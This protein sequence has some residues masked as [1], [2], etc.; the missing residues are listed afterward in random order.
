M[1]G[2]PA[3]GSRLVAATRLYRLPSSGER[4]TAAGIFLGSIASTLGCLVLILWIGT[5]WAAWKL[6]YQPA[7]GMPLYAPGPDERRWLLAAVGVAAALGVAALLDARSRRWS[8]ALFAAALAAGACWWGPVY[9]PWDFFLWE[10]RYGSVPEAEAI[11]RTGHWL[12]GAP[13]HFV[14]L[15]GVALA[16]RRAR[17][18]GGRT[19]SHGSA[20]WA[21]QKD[22]ARTGL[23]DA[24]GVYVGGW[25][26]LG[27]MVPLRHDGPQH[28]LGFAPARSGKGVGWVIPTL[29]A[30]PDSVVVN[31]IKGENW[32][33]TAGWRQRGLGSLCLK[34]DPTCDDGSA[35][36]YNPLLEVRKGPKE[37]RD[38]QNIADI[39]VDPDG[40]GS[41]D[42]WDLTAQE[43]LAGTI[44]HVLYAGRDKSLRGC[45][46]LLTN[47]HR[48][49]E[50]VLQEMID[51]QHDPVG[52]RNWCDA[53]TGKPTTTHPAVAR[54]ARSL[55]NKSEN[56]R[57]SVLSSATKFLSL[58]HDDVVATN[59]AACD[60]SIADLM[61]HDR[62]VSLYLT[63]PPSDLSRV[64]PLL[65]LL[66][67]Q[68]GRRLTERMDF[69][70]GRH[71][72]R[73]RHR[74]LLMLDEFATLGRLDFFQT[75]LSYL[76]GYGVKAFLIVQDLSQLY[77]AYGREE[78]IVSNCH[79]R[80]A[81][82]PNKVETARLLSDMAGAMTVHKETRT[83]TGNRLNPVL[84]HVLAS[85]QESH[86][87]LLTP[88]EVMRLPEDAALVFVSNARP[89]LGQKLRYYRDPDFAGRARVPAPAMSDR[90][91]QR[92]CP[93]EATADGFATVS[94][95]TEPAPEAPEPPTDTVSADAPPPDAEALLAGNAAP[96]PEAGR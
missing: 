54:A 69:E 70:D 44:L 89:I 37:I 50:E 43:I 48:P 6:G 40:N 77:A 23:L 59:T 46:D 28:V 58:Y 55:L 31:D 12:I 53:Q 1:A 36:R 82:A 34:F 25:L 65:R 61:H 22:V 24:G 47:P 39:L 26:Q 42:H 92:A 87:L 93:W 91:A 71:V 64:R 73:Y 81:Y 79:V 52:E 20:R 72:P 41:K 29:L 5:Q 30:W 21:D 85:E 8:P 45:L 88:D 16:V 63:V 94:R 32:A 90:L 60:F 49:I 19:D 4:N 3:A 9:A 66:I 27:R 14:F 18:L 67:N 2:I 51:T 7:L 38:V 10:L 56:E 86:R 68:I 57:S 80:V 17:K 84:M 35:A 78:S 15:V 11:W 96:A 76:A 13:A 95:P 75:Q 33:L 83:Y 62:P 74:L